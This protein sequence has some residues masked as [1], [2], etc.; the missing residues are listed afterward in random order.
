MSSNQDEDIEIIYWGEDEED[1]IVD[2]EKYE[3]HREKDKKKVNWKK[4]VFS[5]IK[6][7]VWA[8][9]I[10]LIINNF[11]IINA[12]VP[13]G[14][15]HPTIKKES[16]MVGFRLSYLFSEPKQGDIIIFK[17]PDNEEENFVKRVIATEG[18]T[19]EIKKGIVYVDGKKLDEEK[20]VYYLGGSPNVN[21]N[22]A[23]TTVPKNCYF[24]LGDNRNNS[25]DSRY[26]ET[27]HF[28]SKDQVLGKAIFS[29]YPE[30]KLLK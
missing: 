20:Y 16:R 4:E 10:A 7:I 21:D 12:E 27:T 3:K 14:S 24:V 17:F 8:V 30:I 2:A 25:N 9:V 29:Y 5:W 6:L 28:V 23:K 18:Q 15:M 26:W 1:S 19:V 22:F 13:T 11:V